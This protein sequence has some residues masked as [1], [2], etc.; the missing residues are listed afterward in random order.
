MSEYDAKGGGRERVKESRQV[1][2]ADPE[3]IKKQSQIYHPKADDKLYDYHEAINTPLR[4]KTCCCC[5][6]KLSYKGKQD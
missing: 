3:K 4:W 5:V 6:I 1:V 2:P